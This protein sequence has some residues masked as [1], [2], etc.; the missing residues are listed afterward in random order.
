M[1]PP[2]P[3]LPLPK[4]VTPAV[5]TTPEKLSVAGL[6]DHGNVEIVA[7]TGTGEGGQDERAKP[8][9]VVSE[10]TVAGSHG[11]CMVFQRG[12]GSGDWNYP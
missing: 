12:E 10:A 1:P 3:P 5:P 6:P 11:A 2:P 7:A 8:L 4:V 9:G